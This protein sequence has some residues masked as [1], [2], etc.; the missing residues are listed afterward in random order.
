VAGT[1]GENQDIT[2]RAR[3]LETTS[4]D[5]ALPSFSH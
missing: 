1:G 4:K 5:T 3:L 2:K